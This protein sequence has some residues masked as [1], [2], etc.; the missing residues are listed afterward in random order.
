MGLS[1]EGDFLAPVLRSEE[2]HVVF[3]LTLVCAKRE[4]RLGHIRHGTFTPWRFGMI[5]DQE[6]IGLRERFPFLGVGPFQFMPDHF[7]ALI[8]MPVSFV[9]QDDMSSNNMESKNGGVKTAS[10][11]PCVACRWGEDGCPELIPWP[12]HQRFDYR[13][14]MLSTI[15]GAYKSLSTLQCLKHHKHVAGTPQHTPWMGRL[16]VRGYYARM[17]KTPSEVHAVTRY[18]HN[19]PKNWKKTR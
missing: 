7:H 3:F 12:V 14:P 11:S 1:F 19:N 9:I 5:A 2:V 6:W 4:H 16:W 18:I 10:R 17:L 13:P 15:I 8:S